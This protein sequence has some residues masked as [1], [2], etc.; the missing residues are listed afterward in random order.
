MTTTAVLAAGVLLLAVADGVR[1]APRIQAL[2]PPGGQRGTEVVVAVTGQRLFEPQ[3][4]LL[5]G[6]GLEV[7]AIVA[8][9]KPE[10]CK[11]T[12]RIA[13]DCP[14]GQHSLRLRTAFGLSNLVQFTVGVLPEVKEQRDGDAVQ[15][16]ALPC[17]VNGSVRNEEVDRYAVELVAGQQLRCEVE[18]LRLGFG[19]ADLALAVQAPDGS[20]VARA[21]DT[22]LGRK[23][24]W[25]ACAALAAGKYVV[26][27][28]CAYAGNAGGQY[29][30]HVGGFPRPTGALPCGGEH[31]G[32]LSLALLGECEPLRTT[33]R[34]PDSGGD[35]FAFFP[36]DARG[37]APTPIWLRV[38]GPPNREPVPDDQGHTWIE[39]PGTVHGVIAAPGDIASYC[40]HGKRGEGLDLRL[41]ARTLRSPLEAVL[42]VQKQDGRVLASADGQ[43]GID[44]VLRFDPPA[45]GDYRVEVRDQLRTGSPSHVFRLECKHHSDVPNCRLV[46]GRG[47]N[48]VVVVPRGSAAAAVMQLTAIDPDAGL[49]LQLPDLPAGVVAQFGPLLRGSNLVPLLLTASADAP[50]AGAQ[51]PVRATATKEPHERDPGYA[52]LIALVTGRNDAPLLRASQ[53]RLPIAVVQAAPFTVTVTAPAVPIV[54]GAGL[55]LSVHV[56]RREGFAEPVRV[57]AVWTPP[58]ISCGQVVIDGKSEAGV[59]PLD[60]NGEAPVGTFQLAIVGAATWRGGNLEVA[61]GYV[62]LAVD[63][64]WLIAQPGKART[65]QGKPVALR[66]ALERQRELP[67]P[68][69]AA[70]LGLPRGVASVDLELPADATELVFPL[71]VA[72]D[73]ATGKHK[74]LTVELRVRSGDATVVHRFGAGELRVD[75]PKVPAMAAG[76]Q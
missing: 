62:P 55:G 66:L 20:V 13:A 58:G 18:A 76:K 2:E 48:A 42:Q 21:D 43:N 60:A 52:Q 28:A 30:L 67:G 75:Q 40:F 16:I 45:D 7:T 71:T 9:D 54:R 31:G 63:K 57:R 29:R 6:P 53:R 61:T 4:L 38:G 73:A 5:D 70:L 37:T 47:E 17:T 46:V 41:L 65:E 34:L 24:P 44:P 3:G 69:H 74:N 11:V 72:A 23:D 33:V 12:L 36:V 19:L 32:E 8:G 26:S 1:T 50:L 59:L 56:A 15:P 27:V 64:P 25:L 51:V 10:D 49:Q 68:L 39:L 22:A 14:L 35:L